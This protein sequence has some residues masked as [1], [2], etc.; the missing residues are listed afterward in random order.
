MFKKVFLYCLNILFYIFLSILF[1]TAHPECSGAESEILIVLPDAAD[2]VKQF[3]AAELKMHLNLIY[4]NEVKSLKLKDYKQD[5][6][7]KTFFVGIQPGSDKKALDKEEARYKIEEN[8]IYLYGED[9]I[10]GRE[11]SVSQSV[12]DEKY[13]RCGTL[14]GVYS[15]LENE[16]G[17]VWF[18]PGNEGIAY[19]NR[20]KFEFQNKSFSWRPELKQRCFRIHVKDWNENLDTYDRAFEISKEA[21]EQKIFDERVWLRRMR[22][23]RSEIINYGHAFTAWWSKYGKSHPEFFALLKET[24]ERA[25]YKASKGDR[26]KMCVSNPS[27]HREIIA[28]W[29]ISKS[30]NPI[31]NKYINVCEN[32]SKGYCTCSACLALDLR[33][34]GEAFDEFMTDR[35]VWFANQVVK[36]AKEKDSAAKVFIY[37]YSDYRFPPRREKLSADVVIGIVPDLLIDADVLEKNYKDWQAAGAREILLRPN[38]MHIDF[39]MPIGFEKKMFDN[40]SIG[41]KN[42]V[43]GTD[44]TSLHD[45]WETSGI[46][47]YILAKAHVYPSEPFEKWEDE[48]CS[49][50]GAAKDEVKEYFQYWRKVFETR[51]Y[52]DREAIIKAGRYGNFR[53][54]MMWKLTAYYKAEDFDTTDKILKRAIALKLDSSERERLARLMQINNHARLTYETVFAQNDEKK[55]PVD[56]INASRKLFAFRLENKD[57]LNMNWPL[58]FSLEKEFGDI[59]G[60][61]IS[62]MFDDKLSPV[63]RLSLT[64]RFRTDPGNVGIHEKWQ[65]SKWSE[66]CQTWNTVRIDQG[67]TKQSDKTM[68]AELRKQL[69]SYSG[70][71]WY[72][73][74]L[75]IGEK[76]KKA[77]VYLTFGA[78]DKSCWVY[79]N[80]HLSGSHIYTAAEDWR[81]P[82]SIRIDE[83]FSDS[84]EQNIIVRVE[85][86]GI[87]GI[88]K[89][90]WLS[91]EK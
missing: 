55:S 2:A 58:L 14:F 38:D 36:A 44:Y 1:S 53:R 80:G 15:F 4:S 17:V 48:Y 73:I 24:G 25:P 34:D 22:M 8:R 66:I 60:I 78:V 69:E 42:G 28:Q 67:W 26:I 20:N 84:K 10:Q 54:G 30:R 56:K 12:L 51:F 82:F 64:W 23:G 9:I 72:A 79:V 47:D 52:P 85:S 40:F 35:Y 57:K 65:L 6:K 37:A 75:P 39:G 18:A 16:L 71:A 46:A 90:V 61:I 77:K 31:D 43:F 29:E 19:K 89:P 3:A 7:K 81:M 76:L 86:G 87:G 91:T 21:L 49:I 50:Y 68:S 41:V 27:L 11:V 13:T 74:N 33:K 32:D 45:F 59:T 5:G 63:S 62:K 88:W 83:H 70:T